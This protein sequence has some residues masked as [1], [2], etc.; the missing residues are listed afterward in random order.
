V[1]TTFGITSRAMCVE[2]DDQ[3]VVVRGLWWT[4]RRIPTDRIVAVTSYPS[5][6]YRSR[7]GRPRRKR[8]G[9]FAP[10]RY[11]DPSQG[12]RRQMV[13]HIIQLVRSSPSRD[14]RKLKYLDRE[15]LAD[16]QRIADAGFR[17]ASR[18]PRADRY[19]LGEYWAKQRH[20]LET[21]LSSRA[22]A[23]PARSRA[24]PEPGNSTGHN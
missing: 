12:M 22:K 4:R 1:A 5:I 14:R 8:I 19:G 10:N 13:Q 11:A 17:W 23:A 3:F 2:C 16:Q 15:A 7:H 24:V 18:H 6:I 20:L 9:F 21:E